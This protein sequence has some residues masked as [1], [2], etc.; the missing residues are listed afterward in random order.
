MNYSLP[1]DLIFRFTLHQSGSSRFRYPEEKEEEEE[2]ELFL[3]KTLVLSVQH[4]HTFTQY[5][6]T[7]ARGGAEKESRAGN[8]ERLF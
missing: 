6:H 4:K 3:A 2:E 5:N 8:H 7:Q 1:V